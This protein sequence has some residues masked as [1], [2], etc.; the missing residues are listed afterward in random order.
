[1]NTTPRYE[2]AF[3]GFSIH[4]WGVLLQIKSLLYGLRDVKRPQPPSPS[5]SPSEERHLLRRWAG[6][7]AMP[8][9]P[10]RWKPDAVAVDWH[11]A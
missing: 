10:S 4:V 11:V 6:R 7:R 8:A 9:I 2:E 5:P 3:H 1:M